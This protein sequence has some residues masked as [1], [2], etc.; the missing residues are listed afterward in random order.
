MLSWVNLEAFVWA[1][2]C[3]VE[4][5]EFCR[6]FIIENVSLYIYTNILR[7]KAFILIIYSILIIKFQ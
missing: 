2:D 6:P 5:Y 7:I 3:D 1:G 4:F